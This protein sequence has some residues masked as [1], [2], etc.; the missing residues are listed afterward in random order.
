MKRFAIAVDGPAGSGKSTVAKAVAK[1]GTAYYATLAEAFA[2]IGS[3]DVVIE[4]LVREHLVERGL[5]SSAKLNKKA[6]ICPKN[7]N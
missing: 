4:L 5:S 3:G 1:I 6:L 2:A 7:T